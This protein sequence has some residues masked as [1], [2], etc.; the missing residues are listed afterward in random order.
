MSRNTSGAY[1]LPSGNPVVAGTTIEAPWANTTLGDVAAELSNSL[2]RYGRGGMLAAFKAVNGTVAAPGIAFNNESSTGLSLISA[3]DMRLS[4]S[5]T[6]LIKFTPTLVTVTGTVA[7]TQF[8]GGGAGITGLSATNLASGTVPSARLGSGTANATTFLRGDG[9]WVAPPG[10]PGGSGTVTS[11][12]VTAP[13]AGLTVSGSPIAGAGTFVFALADDLAAV[14]AIA[15][16]GFVK[17]TAVNTWSTAAQIDLAT[18]VNGNLAVARLNGGTSAS[19][20]TFWRGD[21]TWASPAVSAVSSVAGRTGAVVLTSSDVGLAN[22]TNTSDANKPVSTAQQIALNLKAN[23]NDPALTGVATINGV[24]IGYLDIP[25]RTSGVAR[26]ECLAATA[27]F[28]LNTSDL[29]AGKAYSVYND[30]GSSIVITQGGGVTLRLAGSATTG[31]RTLAA[32]G[33]ATIWC[34]SAS[35]A[36]MFGAGLT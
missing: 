4:V 19:A 3:G 15:T 32:R 17:R 35:E 5:G 21:G 29:S 33:M 20:S 13:A 2:D 24:V 16:T 6:E 10:G 7:A 30:S 8:V 9:Q 36:V 23:L 14:E 34:N 31:N 18:E 12:A 25:R 28:T 27:G 26:G 1:S 11:V 22:V